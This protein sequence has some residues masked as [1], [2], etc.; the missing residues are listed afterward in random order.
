MT[1]DKREPSPQMTR[2][3]VS[4]GVATERDLVRAIAR[5]STEM[6]GVR[7][8]LVTASIILDGMLDATYERMASGGDDLPEIEF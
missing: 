7:T 4:Y 2:L 1:I 6:T 3:M 8:S 5:E